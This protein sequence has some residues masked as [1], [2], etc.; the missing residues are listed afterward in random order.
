VHRLVHLGLIERCYLQYTALSNLTA[1]IYQTTYQLKLV[2]TAIFSILFFRT[3]VSRRRWFSLFLLTLG[4]AIVQLESSSNS[5]ESSPSIQHSRL[6]HQDPKKGFGAIF[7][8]CIS[9][10]LA[11]AWFEKVLKTSPPSTPSI[12]SSSTP[13][14]KW[15]PPPSLWKR[16]L[17]LS[18]P[19]LVF[20]SIGVYLSTSSSTST[21]SISNLV[22]LSGI[23]GLW[24]GFT[25]LVWFVVLNQ[26][27]GGLLVALVRSS[28]HYL[29][30][31]MMG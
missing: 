7:L 12:S 3:Q 23:F 18:V 2:T 5:A 25:P 21:R 19:S 31:C 24:R 13:P 10:G 1:E 22:K 14:P 15:K 11:G 20:A 8:A 16:N 27:A 9:S 28:S 26:A 30:L 29:T 4:V 17:Q 6:A